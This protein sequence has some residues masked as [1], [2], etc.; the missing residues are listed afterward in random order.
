MKSLKRILKNKWVA[1]ALLSAAIFIVA[2][3][4]MYLVPWLIVQILALSLGIQNIFTTI[5]LLTIVL[6]FNL[7]LSPLYVLEASKALGQNERKKRKH[8]KTIT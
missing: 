7:L 8:K 2:C 1:I 6:I 3:L 5:P 4:I